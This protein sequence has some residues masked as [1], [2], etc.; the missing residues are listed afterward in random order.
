[1][2]LGPNKVSNKAKDEAIQYKLESPD[3]NYQ[4]KLRFEPTTGRCLGFDVRR[5]D[6]YRKESPNT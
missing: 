5:L 3:K 2:R 1:M 6:H 4:P